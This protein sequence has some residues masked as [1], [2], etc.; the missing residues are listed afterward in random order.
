MYHYYF[1]QFFQ[2]ITSVVNSM[3]IK[4]GDKHH[5]L[6]EFL[7]IINSV[8]TFIFNK[9]GNKQLSFG[10]KT[11]CVWSLIDNPVCVY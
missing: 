5:Y 1:H 2:P 4:Q 7:E 3:F 10:L 6:H 8:A 11:N 9:Q